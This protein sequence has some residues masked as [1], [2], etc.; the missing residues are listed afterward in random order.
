MRVRFLNLVLLLVVTVGLGLLPTVPIHADGTTWTPTGPTEAFSTIA[1]NPQNDQEVFATGASGVWKTINSGITWN[2]VSTQRLSHDIAIDPHN[3]NILYSLN[4]TQVLK[5]TNGGV[6]WSPIYTSNGSELLTLA[7]DPIISGLI[8]VGGSDAA[9]QAILLRSLDAGATWTQILPAEMQGTT[10]CFSSSTRHVTTLPT[11]PRFVLVMVLTASTCPDTPTTDRPFL[12]SSADAGATWRRIL[13][14]TTSETDFLHGLAGAGSAVTGSTLYLTRF[15]ASDRLLRSTNGGQTWT[16]LN[17]MVPFGDQVYISSLVV[18]SEH[19]DWVY[20]ALVDYRTNSSKGVFASPDGGTTWHELGHLDRPIMDLKLAVTSHIVYAATDTGIYQLSIQWP[21]V[22]RFADYYQRHDGFRLLGNGISL[23]LTLNGYPIQYF[24]KGR[25]EDH[26]AE[27]SDPNWRFMYGLLVDELQQAQAKLPI[28]G[29]T[30]TLTYADLNALADP[31]KRV[32]PPAGYPSRGVYPVTGAVFVPFTTNLSGGPGHYVL[33]GFWN[34][35]NQK[36]LFPGGWLH[37]VGLPIME[38]Q[39]VVVTK[40]FPSGSVQRTITVQ[41]FQ[42]TILTYDPAN[43]AD[44]QIE[45]ANVGTD[46]RLTFPDRV[47]P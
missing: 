46:Y 11:V 30:S 24:E 40:N 4:G 10:G 8:Y 25:I 38:P 43:P 15:S 44:W 3:G 23:E 6:D 2:R 27:S 26:Q 42:R 20:I 14:A 18:H 22:A 39:V 12:A 47:G 37:D 31:G 19:P 7:I 9:R 17:A 13:T 33:G 45:R 34:Y 1:V 35:I 28:G 32:A 5:S 36:D 21:P 41:A 16:N 29:D